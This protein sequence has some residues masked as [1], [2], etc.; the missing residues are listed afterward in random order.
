MKFKCEQNEKGN[1]IVMHIQDKV[2][3]TLDEKQEEKKEEKLFAECEKNAYAYT[4]KKSRDEIEL[5][6]SM[7]ASFA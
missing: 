2:N 5:L 1:Q 6:K 7:R 3:G 4:Y